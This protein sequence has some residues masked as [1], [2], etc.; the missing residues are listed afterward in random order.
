MNPTFEGW[1]SAGGRVKLQAKAL[2]N[3]LRQEALSD[4]SPIYEPWQIEDYRELSTYELFHRLETLGLHLTEENF[5]IYGENYDN[6]EELTLTIWPSQDHK[7]HIYLLLFELWRRLL[8]EKQSLSIF[9]DELDHRIDLYE[10]DPISQESALQNMLIRF[11]EILNEQQDTGSKPKVIFQAIALHSAH[12]LSSFL[13]HYITDQI[14]NE[15]FEYAAEL[16][17]DFYPFIPDPSGF[18]F[19]NVQILAHT[20]IHEANLVLQRILKELK[21][22][23]NLDLLLEISSFLTSHGDP[24]LFHQAVRQAFELIRIEEDFQELLAIAADYYGFCDMEEEEKKLQTIFT[25]RSG[26][27]PETPLVKHD[28]DV[29]T[30]SSFLE[31]ADW[32]KI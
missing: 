25:K 4:P 22:T 13:Y 3:L 17:E 31:D 30:F 2:H 16:V 28:P 15:H 8:P 7:D 14:D 5:L 26:K 20:N 19:L 11:G 6:P 23:G 18:D 29:Q 10:K 27:D 12:D 1:V 24:H 9:C 32:S 21:K